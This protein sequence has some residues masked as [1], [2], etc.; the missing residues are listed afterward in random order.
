MSILALSLLS[1]AEQ[2]GD[3]QSVLVFSGCPNRIPQ[4]GWLKQEKCILSPF[5]RPDVWAQGVSSFGSSWGSLLSL[6]TAAF[7]LVLTRPFLCGHTLLPS[8]RR[9]PVL[10]D[11]SP[12]VWLHLTFIPSLKDMSLNIVTQGV[13]ASTYE[14]GGHISAHDAKIT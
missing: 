9:T 6:H 7:L 10:L 14:F 1:V 11:Q 4:T 2:Q 5:W 3:T 13:K 12:P 8:L